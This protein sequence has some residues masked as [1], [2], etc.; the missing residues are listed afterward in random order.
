MRGPLIETSAR[1]IKN[2]TLREN[3]REMAIRMLKKKKLTV[4][5][6]SEYSGL[7]IIEIEQLKTELT[8]FQ[9]V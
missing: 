5:E 7:S 2:E 1:K 8:Q 9:T 3:A 4:E 6:I